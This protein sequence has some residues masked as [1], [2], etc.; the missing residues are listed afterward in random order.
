M[1]GGLIRFLT[2]VFM[3]NGQAFGELIF[4]DGVEGLACTLAPRVGPIV[5]NV[6]SV[7]LTPEFR[8]NG[9][10]FPNDLANSAT[11]E[12]LPREGGAPIILGLS[13]SPGQPVRIL[14]GLYDVYYRWRAGNGVPRNNRA[15]VQQS[16]LIEQT[17]TLLI[18][19]PSTTLRG[20]LSLNGAPFPLG[21]ATA[22]SL[23]LDSVYGLGRVPLGSSDSRTYVTQLIP[24]SYRLRYL[25]A[26]TNR[27]LPANQSALL[28]R[29]DI[30]IT[31]MA[32][33]F[34]VN[35]TSVVFNFALNGAAFPDSS[36][37]NGRISLRS[38]DDDRVELGFSRDQARA[39]LVIDG[40]YNAH[41]QAIAGSNVPA[42]VDSPFALNLAIGA[43]NTQLL[44]VRTQIIT[45]NFLVNGAP[46]PLS[47][48][49]NARIYLADA[50]GNG[51]I[52]LGETRFGEFNRTLIPGRYNLIYRRLTGGLVMP[53]NTRKQ[54][55]SRRDISAI[56]NANIDIPVVP[57]N[58]Q[59][60]L[61]G[62]AYPNNA[63]ESGRLYFRNGTIES[64]F[65][66]ANTHTIGDGVSSLV[67]PGSYQLLYR[68]LTCAGILAPH[69][70]NATLSP[71]LHADADPS[72]RVI[73]TQ[74]RQIE[75]S[76]LHN[77]VPF[78]NDPGRVARIDW[79]LRDDSVTTE[80]T[81]QNF[82]PRL[83]LTNP[84]PLADG[85]AGSAVYSWIAGGRTEMPQNVDQAV[86]CYRFDP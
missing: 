74:M 83:L 3:L 2:L 5:M 48:L 38:V 46:A 36:V 28:E 42:N 47:V 23:V 32:H 13:S 33:D 45:G 81:D 80:I 70:T 16:V 29:V 12:L 50:L 66:A 41:W 26:G 63:L 40:I 8:L 22:A 51:E 34:N 75:F 49:E 69:N 6:R 14:T 55:I 44:D 54:F 60:L 35:A 15:L 37:E 4:R 73:D 17:Q 65:A 64:E 25:S 30:D 82:G 59:V 57:L 19:V 21:G 20:N 1:R 58:W 67:I 52:L 77:G 27:N 7:L 24:G 62:A 84:A 43:A 39:A 53:A 86:A 10:A 18:N 79:R 11:F 85:R 78:A 56:P 61:N 72:L 31:T 76:H 68:C 71:E 9:A